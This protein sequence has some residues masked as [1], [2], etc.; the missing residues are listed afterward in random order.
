MSEQQPQ[1]GLSRRR[2]LTLAGLTVAGGALSACT[3]MPAAP[4]AS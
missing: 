2:F 1:H 3:A 4:A